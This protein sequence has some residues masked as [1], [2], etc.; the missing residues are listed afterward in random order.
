MSIDVHGFHLLPPP[1]LDADLNNAIE[2]YP[3]IAIGYY[4]RGLAY[5]KTAGF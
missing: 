3:D 1:S 5:A 4:Y 2:I